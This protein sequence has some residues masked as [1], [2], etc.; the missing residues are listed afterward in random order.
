MLSQSDEY[1]DTK[2][3]THFGAYDSLNLDPQV[4]YFSNIDVK[5]KYALA[6]GDMVKVTGSTSNNFVDRVI[7]GFGTDDLGS[8]IEF[9]ESFT[10]ELSSSGTAHFKSQYNVWSE[11]MGMTPYD[12]DVQGH[13]DI[14]TTYY[15]SIP[16]Y[17][18]YFKGQDGE[19][20]GKDFLAKE[21]YFPASL[22]ALPRKTRAGC[23]ITIPP[24]N[25]TG[26]KRID[27]TNVVNAS[28]LRP[29][30]STNKNFYNSIVLK[31][32]EMTLEDKF[33]RGQIFYSA[34]SQTRFANQG[35]KPLTIESK[36]L[37]D[38]VNTDSILAINA[39]RWLQRYRFAAESFTGVKVH[40]K[41]GLQVEIGD[42]VMFGDSD[43]N[44]VDLTRGDRDF[45]PKIFEVVN[46]S[47]N[48]KNGEVTL[49]LLSTGFDSTSRYGGIS[50]STEVATGST[51]T[52]IVIRPTYGNT[53][54][55]QERAKWKSLI[56]QE[57]EIHNDDYSYSEVTTLTALSSTNEAIFEVSPAVATPPADGYYIDVA[58]YP[59][60][61][62]VA[63]RSLLKGVFTFV[64]RY[65]TV[66]TGP[67]QTEFEVG[68]GD[69]QY[70]ELGMRI[71][72]HNDTWSIV[73]ST[74]EVTLIVGTTITVDSSLNVPWESYDP[75][76]GLIVELLVFND[77]GKPYTMI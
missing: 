34:D 22:Y 65:A 71:F 20:N 12:V 33:S 11:G 40:F 30:R 58:K 60:T 17:D 66:V 8:W 25:T 53:T 56:G 24:V 16:E 45:E 57:I 77:D 75:L 23:Q 28:S 72:M 10:T 3:V 35:N 52:N 9:A 6:I 42:V 50:P 15:S 5:E 31:Y 36:G 55:K 74:V 43:L 64:D 67:S 70:F 27:S 49:D 21:V 38:S 39:T 61:S 18:F 44:I 47:I 62:D 46:K 14:A 54:L 41:A 32:D 19:I 63:D 1:Y 29:T 76:A 73:S 37:R 69:V 4:M 13:I 7:T 51:T 2:T 59:T 26:L 68:A 48:L